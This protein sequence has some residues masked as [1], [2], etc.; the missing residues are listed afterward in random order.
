MLLF[1]SMI[2]IFGGCQC[3]MEGKGGRQKSTCLR[4]AI[5]NLLMESIRN[6]DIDGLRNIIECGLDVDFKMDNN[7][8]IIDYA[9]D[10]GKNRITLFL[11]SKGACAK[12]TDYYDPV[13]AI[14]ETD[15]SQIV[16]KELIKHGGNIS[17]FDRNGWKPIHHAR[18]LMAV[19]ILHEFG[20]DIRALTADGDCQLIH[21]SAFNGDIDVVRFLVEHGVDIETKTKTGKTPIDYA[22]MN[23]QYRVI[24]YLEEEKA[25]KNHRVGA[26]QLTSGKTDPKPPPAN[27]PPPPTGEDPK[28]KN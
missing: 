12:H 19:R 11:L 9:V 24:E 14:S 26:Q 3:V 13:C 18:Y 17:D 4:T 16:L 7:M 2:V 22:G 20:A 5:S 10:Q 28:P 21:I 15:G 6:D 1:I 8:R 25:R 27:D 23:H